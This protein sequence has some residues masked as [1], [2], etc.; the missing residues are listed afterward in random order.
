VVSGYESVGAKHVNVPSRP[1]DSLVPLPAA[2]DLHGHP[3]SILTG[4]EPDRPRK[5]HQYG[6]FNLLSSVPWPQSCVRLIIRTRPVLAP[7]NAA[8]A[9][10]LRRSGH[11]D[12]DTS[13]IFEAWMTYHVLRGTHSKNQL[14]AATQF[15]PTLLTDAA[16]SNVTGGQRIEAQSVGDQV[17]FLSG[18]KSRSN[19]V[20]AV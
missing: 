7:S 9:D 3:N 19:L 8:I 2:D 1:E 18:N 20:E 15:P 14:Q 12:N 13:A 5:L 10:Y 17:F 16:Y 6:A 11:A 4:V